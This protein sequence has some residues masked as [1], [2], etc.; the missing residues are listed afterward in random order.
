MLPPLRRVSAAIGRRFDRAFPVPAVKASEAA[1][2]RWGTPFLPEEHLDVSAPR[3]SLPTIAVELPSSRCLFVEGGTFWP[4]NGV[5]ADRNGQ[6]IVETA[7]APD[8]FAKHQAIGSFGRFPVITS[9][10]TAATAQ[11]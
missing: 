4:E 9:G 11:Q 6:A 7:W 5:V 8:R 10:A 3:T 1:G 2:C